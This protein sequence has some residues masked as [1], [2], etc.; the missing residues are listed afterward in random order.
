[1]D[2]RCG[3]SRRAPELEEEGG[4]IVFLDEGRI[5]AAE[6][7]VG[8]VPGRAGERRIAQRRDTHP[9][10]ERRQ[11]EPVDYAVAVVVAASGNLRSL[12]L[13][14]D[15]PHPSPEAGGAHDAAVLR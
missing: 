9:A 5:R 10:G 12:A 4:E 15:L 7:D 3:G 2:L 11:I 8:V 13:D 6:I 14:V 1:M